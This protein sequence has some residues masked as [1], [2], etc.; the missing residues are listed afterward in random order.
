MIL[1]EIPLPSHLCVMGKCFVSYLS[2]FLI[3]FLFAIVHC[4][5][6]EYLK[7][8]QK[9]IILSMDCYPFLFLSSNLE[10]MCDNVVLVSVSSYHK[11]LSSGCYC[12]ITEEHK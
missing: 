6:W 12:T 3:Y 7:S 10:E 2:I 5:R 8:C 11:D 9:V 4:K 1:T